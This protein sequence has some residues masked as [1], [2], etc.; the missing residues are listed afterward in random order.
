M[1]F[2]ANAEEKRSSLAAV[3][4]SIDGLIS[5]KHTG[6]DFLCGGSSL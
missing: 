2:S 1:K 6:G 4:E 5:I 3:M